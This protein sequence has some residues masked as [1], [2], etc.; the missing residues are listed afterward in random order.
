MRLHDL[1]GPGREL[2]K[3]V[4]ETIQANADGET[5]KNLKSKCST[6]I[7]LACLSGIC[8]RGVRVAGAFARFEGKLLVLLYRTRS[9]WLSNSS[10]VSVNVFSNGFEYFR[11]LKFD[12]NVCIRFKKLCQR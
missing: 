2:P 6:I 12:H 11:L 4:L 9:T 3:D 10:K 8:P 7:A 1:G 5:E